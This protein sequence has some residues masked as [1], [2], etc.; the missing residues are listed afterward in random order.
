[1]R[2]R[3]PAQSP[4]ARVST[5]A[6]PARVGLAKTFLFS[7]LTITLAFALAA[8]GFEVVLRVVFRDRGRTTSLGPG[9]DR[10]AFEYTYN[11][12]DL[13]APVVARG[14]RRPGVTRIL[15]Q[16]D[17]IT[18]GHGVR[19]WHDLYP[20]RL[21]RLLNRDGER[22]ELAVIANP[23]RETFDHAVTLATYLEEI[24]P[25][26]ILYQWYVNDLEHDKERRPRDSEVLWRRWP[27]HDTA[28][29]QSF[30]YF[31]LDH[32]LDT[33]PKRY[34]S[35]L[36]EEFAEWNPA[37]HTYEQQF[38]NWAEAAT[39]N[40]ERAILMLYPTLGPSGRIRSRICGRGSP[41]SP[42]LAG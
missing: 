40:S 9:G 22:Y 16:G 18:W 39:A 4:V 29:K 41:D 31:L 2:A 15:I 14:P 11:A 13:R 42:P 12:P 26:I 8:L 36:R 33:T 25:D 7:V 30:L 35:Y 21:L 17:S 32:R 27:F 20:D 38:H 34:L 23:G 24:S 28:R 19:D 10:E 3:N 37:W 1:M 6:T 5:K